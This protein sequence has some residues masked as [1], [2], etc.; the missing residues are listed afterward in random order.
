M[1]TNKL[2]LNLIQS[3]IDSLLDRNLK[4]MVSTRH[5]VL[6]AAS[7]HLFSAG[8][9]R[10][11]P[12]LVLLVAKAL[13][14]GEILSSQK[15]LAE[16]T[17]IIHTASLVHD[18]ILDDCSTRRGV[19]TV[20]NT[21]SVKIAVLAGDYLFAQSSWYLANLDSLKVVQN[22]SKVISDFAEGEIRQGLILFDIDFS[23]SEYLEKSF[24]KTA[25]LIAASCQGAAI[26]NKLDDRTSKKLY[27]YGK[28]LGLAFQI[29]DDI[30]DL[31][32]SV[33]FLGKLPGSDLKNG[34]LTAPILFAITEQKQISILVY[35]EFS[36]K[37]DIQL[38]IDL[39]TSSGGIFKAKDMASEHIEAALSSISDLE[40]S[41]SK[42]LLQKVAKH[43]IERLY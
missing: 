16:I 26:L 1:N 28:H 3:D 27:N 18:D 11:R 20:H 8:G 39:I 43:T 14:N 33:D 24:Y 21:F 15:R 23:I 10:F 38:G 34:N 12:A 2:D 13:N 31:V 32:G 6:Y 29:I 37:N 35:R 9:K 7:E 17:E 42:K 36:K 25:S 41:E 30:L 4:L 19:Q 22:I 5:P 40:D